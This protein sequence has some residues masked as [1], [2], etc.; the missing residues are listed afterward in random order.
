M[1]P[2]AQLRDDPGGEGQLPTGIKREI[3]NRTPAKQIAEGGQQTFG[4]DRVLD[5]LLAV[6]LPASARKALTVAGPGWAAHV[7]LSGIETPREAR[8]HLSVEPAETPGLDDLPL[9][10]R[11]ALAPFLTT[12]AFSVGGHG[13][14][15]ERLLNTGAV[16][17]TKARPRT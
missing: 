11:E 7:A 2:D 5:Y 9:C 15:G 4:R 8:I 16:R 10:A 6:K 13:A 1:D 17:L 12:L 3:R 14:V